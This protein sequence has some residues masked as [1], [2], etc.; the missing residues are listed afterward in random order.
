MAASITGQ[1]LNQRDG[2][3]IEGANVQLAGG[4]D[5]STSSGPEGHFAFHDLA[6]G[7][8]DLLVTKVGFE[9]GNYGPL[10]LLDDTTLHLPLA[11]QPKNI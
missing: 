9:D 4:S 8:Y 3:P 2:Q 5:Q 10:V 6:E 1:V 11:L 7:N